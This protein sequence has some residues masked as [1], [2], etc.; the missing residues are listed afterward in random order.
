[1]QHRVLLSLLEGLG[2]EVPRHELRL[3]LVQSL[4]AVVA[5]LAVESPVPVDQ[6]HLEGPL[7]MLKCLISATEC[8]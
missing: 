3:R 1:M 2:L 8:R 4:R 6:C 5:G 7:I